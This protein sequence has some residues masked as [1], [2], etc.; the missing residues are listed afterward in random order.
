MGTMRGFEHTSRARGPRARSLVVAAPALATLT[1]LVPATAPAAVVPGQIVLQSGDTPT[2]GAAVVDL[3]PPFVNTAGQV[4]FVGNLDDGDHYVFVGTDV[5]W[6]GSDDLAQLLTGVELTMDSSGAGGFV[7]APDVDGLDGLYTDTGVLAVAGQPAVGFPGGVSYTFHGGASMTADGAIYWV[8]GVDLDGDG[9]SDNR[10]F[11]RT[12]DGTAASIELLL[13][14]GDMVD[15][16]VVDNDPTGIPFNYALSEDGAHRIHVLN[17]EGSTATDGFVW[18]DGVLVAREGDPTGTGDAWQAFDLVAI[19]AGGNYLV[20][21]DTSGPFATDEFLAHNGTIVVREAD[22]VDGIALTGPAELRFASITDVDQAMHA[23]GHQTAGGF[24][25]TV[26][27]A[28]DAADIAGTSQ[29]VFSTIDDELDIDG[30]G[31]GDFDIINLVATG[32]TVG[33]PMGETQFVYAEV[34]LDDGAGGISNAMIEVPVTCCGNGVVNPFE[35]CDDANDVE[36]DDCLSTCAAASCGDGFVWEGV[37]E[38]DDG[39][40]DDTDEC[41]TS[42]VPAVCGDGFVWAGMEECDDGND[43]DTDACLG[44]CV[45]ATC[46]DGIVQEGVE[47]CDDGLP[48]D[49]TECLGD[50]TIPLPP[51]STGTV[52]DSTGGGLDDTAGSSGGN[53]ESGGPGPVSVGGGSESGT[54]GDTDTDTAGAA[55]GGDGCNCSTGERGPSGLGWAVLGLVGLGLARRRRWG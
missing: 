3:G 50:C 17:M 5:V 11:Y 48:E 37:E 32:P 46:G 47:E 29:L 15:A 55:G 26:F 14:G 2:G 52:D 13:A 9:A 34:Q 54:G 31:A 40:V 30:D 22:V 12:P 8:A 53:E 43:D 24:R 4:G 28:C 16:F 23:W 42:C 35:A 6:L 33:R 27:F 19:N 20:T 18:V 1:L 44:T 36:T 7:Y 38:C 10:G 51:G 21:G 41:P 49:D 39:N 25:E 45:A